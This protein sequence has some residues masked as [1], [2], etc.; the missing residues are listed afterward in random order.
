[1]PTTLY[2]PY[3]NTP[4]TQGRTLNAILNEMDGIEGLEGVTVLAATNRPHTLDPALVRPG[5]LDRLV[6]VGLPLRCV[7]CR[8]APFLLRGHGMLFCEASGDQ[9]KTRVTALLAATALTP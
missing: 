5:R 7:Q 9:Y 1:V 8:A 2:S 3:T 6:Y 4:L